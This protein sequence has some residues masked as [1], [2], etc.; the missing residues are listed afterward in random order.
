MA[1]KFDKIFDEVIEEEKNR[2]MNPIDTTTYEIGCEAFNRLYFNYT[3]DYYE[4][5]LGV[6]PTAK[7][8]KYQRIYRKISARLYAY[9]A[10]KQG[11]DIVEWLRSFKKL[12]KELVISF[13]RFLKAIVSGI[14]LLFKMIVYYI[15][16]PFKKD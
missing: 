13:K 10:F 4:R 1:K 6:Y 8:S 15:K 16:R 7:K 2:K 14:I 11:K 9:G 3:N 12:L 5:N